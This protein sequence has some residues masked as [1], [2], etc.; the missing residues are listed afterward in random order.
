[1]GIL[2]SLANVFNTNGNGNRN[3]AV[4]GVENYERGVLDVDY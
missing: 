1:M 2:D 4:N 3:G